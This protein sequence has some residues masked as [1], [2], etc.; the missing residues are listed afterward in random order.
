[1]KICYIYKII[2]LVNGKIYIGQT[3]RAIETRFK[4]HLSD[5]EHRPDEYSYL[6]N[7]MNKYGKENFSVEKV[8]ECNKQELSDNERYY[9]KLYN[10]F[11]GEGYNLTEGGDH[12]GRSEKSKKKQSKTMLGSGNHFYGKHHSKETKRKIVKNRNKTYLGNDNPFYGKKHTQESLDKMKE[13]HY[14]K[15]R[16]FSF[17]EAE[18]IR[19]LRFLN[20]MN[21]NEICNELNISKGILESILKFKKGYVSDKETSK[22]SNMLRLYIKQN[23]LI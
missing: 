13:N 18:N 20:K 10:T 3:N 7:S 12:A 14:N 16:Y 19:K 6:H 21:K 15:K 17:E 23:K 22:F 2:N 1:M 9:I 11:E 5:A 4:E 8:Y